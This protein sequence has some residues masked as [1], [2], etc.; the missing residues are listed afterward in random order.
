MSE[1]QLLVLDSNHRTMASANTLVFIDAAVDCCPTLATEVMG[2][3][4]A[5]AIDPTEDGIT[6][7]TTAL[8]RYRNLEKLHIVSLGFPEGLYLGNGIL[9]IETLHAYVHPL[10]DW[11]DSMKPSASIFLHGCNVIFGR[12]GM[13]LVAKLSHLTGVSVAVA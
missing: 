8:A 3:A 11:T 9:T 13:E 2:D 7:I 1:F 4:N 10:M 12:L 5:I 6:Q